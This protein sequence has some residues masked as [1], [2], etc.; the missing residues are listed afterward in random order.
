MNADPH[1]EMDGNAAVLH[2]A[3]LAVSA[4]VAVPTRVEFSNTQS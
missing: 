1:Q 2:R 3:L 4:A